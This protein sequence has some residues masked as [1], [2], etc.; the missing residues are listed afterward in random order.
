VQLAL[1]KG[2]CRVN[3]EECFTILSIGGNQTI[4]NLRKLILED[5]GYR[6]ITCDDLN[7]SLTIV[8]EEAINLIVWD[9]RTVA[10]MDDMQCAKKI[11]K[12]KPD[13]PIIFCIRIPGEISDKNEIGAEVHVKI[14]GPEKLIERVSAVLKKK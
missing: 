2:G 4:L 7:R 12:I 10:H 1:W 11:R 14:D 6:V 5:Q 8:N 9:F 3:E 13:V